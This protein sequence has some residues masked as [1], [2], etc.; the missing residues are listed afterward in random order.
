MQSKQILCPGSLENV[1]TG[2]LSQLGEFFI[3]DIEPAG[4]IEHPHNSSL[5][6]PALG[7]ELYLYPIGHSVQTFVLE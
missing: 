1:P 5:E 6:T 3:V 2:Q 4:H 7:F